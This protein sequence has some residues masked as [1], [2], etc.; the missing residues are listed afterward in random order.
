MQSRAGEQRRDLTTWYVT[1]VN[2]VGGVKTKVRRADGILS[3]GLGLI[4]QPNAVLLYLWSL[5]PS[6]QI[7]QRVLLRDAPFSPTIILVDSVPRAGPAQTFRA[8]NHQAF[9]SSKSESSS[10]GSKTDAERRGHAMAGRSHKRISAAKRHRGFRSMT[11]KPS[12]LLILKTPSSD[13]TR[14]GPPVYSTELFDM[15]LA[16]AQRRTIPS[17]PG[18]M[19]A[20]DT[21]KDG[22]GCRELCTGK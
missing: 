2:G 6:G 3:I 8:A 18:S 1:E 16:C 19:L 22:V 11:E 14:I 9:F 13:E 21:Q 4:C 17:G 15:K 5:A 20:L 10:L 7:V 12:A